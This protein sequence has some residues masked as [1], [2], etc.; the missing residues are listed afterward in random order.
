MKHDKSLSADEQ[1]FME[2]DWK[3][4]VMI[5]VVLSFVLPLLYRRYVPVMGT[6]RI[7]VFHE[8]CE[9]VLVDVRDFHEASHSPMESA[10]HIPLAYLAR[11]H[12]DIPK[13]EVVVV[14]SDRIL[15][16]LS[17]RQ[18]KKHGYDVKGYWCAQD[19]SRYVKA[20]I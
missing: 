8:G 11:Q 17:I 12:H 13:K 14:V 5:A 7:S 18:L 2:G 15:R 16:N 3:M 4:I 10:V 19:A 6:K 20:S 1:H 9:A